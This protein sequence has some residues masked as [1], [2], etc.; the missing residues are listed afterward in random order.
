MMPATY[1]IWKWA[2]NDLPGRPTEIVSQ[3]CAGQLPPALQ[4]FGPEK[5][6][7]I[8]AKVADQRRTEMSEL[9]IEVQAERIR[10]GLPTNCSGR[11]GW[12][13]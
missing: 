7:G 9:L 5:I 11:F 2:D 8:L 12:P 4:P 1:Y 10:L 3:L 13:T 6:L